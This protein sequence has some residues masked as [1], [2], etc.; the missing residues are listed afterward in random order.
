VVEVHVIRARRDELDGDDTQSWRWR[1][2]EIVG[3]QVGG[4]TFILA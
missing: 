2:D 1:V 4:R 3:F